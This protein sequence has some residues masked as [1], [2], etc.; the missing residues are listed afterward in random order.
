M[1]KEGH[2]KQLRFCSV[3]MTIVMTIEIIIIIIIIIGV[4][5]RDNAITV[6]G[7]FTHTNHVDLM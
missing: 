4:I 5:Q 1:R 6:L 2:S 7:T 3:D